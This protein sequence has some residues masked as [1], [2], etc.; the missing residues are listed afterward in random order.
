M[1]GPVRFHFDFISPYSYVASQLLQRPEYAVIAPQYCPVVFG[2]ILSKL[3]VKGPGE[4][5]ARRRQGL[6]DIVLLC[7]YYGLPLKGPP[8][9]PFNSLYALRSVCAAPEP[10][11]AQ[12]TQAYFHAAWAEGRA[13]DNPD[14]LTDILQSLGIDQD[15]V[16]VASTREA[17]LELKQNTKQ[18]LA[19]GAWGV[20]TFLV[21]EQLF[22]GQDRLDLLKRYIDGHLELQTDHVKEMLSRPQPGRV[23]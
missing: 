18:L 10:M 3:G 8:T 15:P 12:L 19:A 7:Q 2:T 6:Q 4:I 14:V 13:L 20:P 21:D 11:K 1:P 23:I 17:R 9:H 22:F 16:E 5:P